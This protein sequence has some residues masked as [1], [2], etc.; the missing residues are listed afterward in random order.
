LSNQSNF[1]DLSKGKWQKGRK[2]LTPFV[3]F[4]PDIKLTVRGYF[5]L[6]YFTV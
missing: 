6:Y 3:E 1:S 5:I 2:K 4:L